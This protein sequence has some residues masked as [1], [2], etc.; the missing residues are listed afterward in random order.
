[1][2]HKVK[3]KNVMEVKAEASQSFPKTEKLYPVF[4]DAWN[5]LAFLNLKYI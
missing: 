1:M 5:N 4:Q 3:N 2:Y